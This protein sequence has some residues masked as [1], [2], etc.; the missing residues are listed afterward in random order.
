MKKVHKTT[1]MPA[2]LVAFQHD[3]PNATW[4]KLRAESRAVYDELCRTLQ[5]DQGGLCAY[6]ELAATKDA[7][8]LQVE[9]IVAKSHHDPA[10][11]WALHW[12]NMLAVCTGGSR[13]A[14]EQDRY[15]EP[16]QDN[17][18][19]DQHKSHLVNTGSLRED[20]RGFVVNPLD[21]PAFPPLVAVL[22]D[23][24]LIPHPDACAQV[25]ISPNAYSTTQELIARSIE[26]LNLNCVRLCLARLAAA[27]N[28]AGELKKAKAESI[29]P[30]FLSLRNGCRRQ[31]FTVYRCRLGKAAEAYLASSGFCG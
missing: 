9:H 4:D 12:P 25:Q 2:P 10:C 23:G 24:R 14:R 26:H 18:S 28:L 16:L 19:C 30:K 27:R 13:W 15:L 5:T 20:S 29:C 22:H 11:N 3:A 1:A 17:L 6:C 7:N 21:L 8:S 31:F